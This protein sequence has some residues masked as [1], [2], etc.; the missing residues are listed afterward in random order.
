MGG[1]SRLPPDRAVFAGQAEDAWEN[2]LIF[3]FLEPD[4]RAESR[5]SLLTQTLRCDPLMPWQAKTF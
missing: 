1:C 3:R 2:C 5:F 4:V